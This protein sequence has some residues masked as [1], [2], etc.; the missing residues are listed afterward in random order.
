MKQDTAR[1]KIIVRTADLKNSVILFLTIL[2]LAC[3]QPDES[4]SGEFVLDSGGGIL[5]SMDEEVSTPAF[6]Y[7]QQFWMSKE[8]ES[9]VLGSYSLDG[10][11]EDRLTLYTTESVDRIGDMD[12][13]S[14]GQ[15]AFFTIVDDGI[16]TNQIV[17][18]Q[19]D[20]GDYDTFFLN[21]TE[22]YILSNTASVYAIDLDYNDGTE[23]VYLGNYY[24]TA[25]GTVDQSVYIYELGVGIS[26]IVAVTQNLSYD[27]EL[28]PQGNAALC[29]D[30]RVDE[31]TGTVGDIAVGLMTEQ[32]GETVAIFHIY[33][34]DG[35]LNFDST[36][37]FEFQD[38]AGV[39]WLGEESM[40]LCV[41]SE[42]RWKIVWGN[43]SGELY[44]VWT[45]DRDVFDM[46]GLDLSPDGDR[47]ISRAI[48]DES[49]EDN[50]ILVLSLK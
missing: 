40:L 29:M 44:T 50:D 33:S 43:S 13:S 38:I 48:Y 41:K 24:N 14:D 37:Q 25:I 6:R 31:T 11:R 23:L 28:T 22:N 16:Y 12:I 2:I 39:Q 3:N 26:D 18:L 8:S 1:R 34:R 46:D 36:D 21:S 35:S 7:Q 27:Y 32:D 17:T 9:R 42:D 10:Y 20:S 49:G 5:L 19:F 47:C 4:L 45:A 30:A 15:S